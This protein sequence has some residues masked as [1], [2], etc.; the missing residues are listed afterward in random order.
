MNGADAADQALAR[1]G[2]PPGGGAGL[3]DR[4]WQGGLAVV[5]AV[6]AALRLVALGADVPAWAEDSAAPL[7]D[8]WWYVH[9]AVCAADGVPV[10]VITGYAPPVWTSIARLWFEAFGAGPRSAHALGA[11]VG[12]TVVALTARLVASMLGRRAGLAAAALL[13]VDPLHVALSRSTLVYGPAT[14]ALVVAAA[15]WWRGA[16]SPAPGAWRLR[17]LGWALAA[18][19]PL[20]VR[21]PAAGLLAGLLA[22]ELALARSR[23]RR[24]LGPAA[25]AAGVL[26]LVAALLLVLDLD[27]GRVVS[28]NLD[29]L[30]R[31]S[32]R[33]DGPVD[34]LERLARVG[35]PRAGAS[36]SGWVALAPVTAALAALGVGGLL[37]GRARPGGSTIALAALGGWGGAF[38]LGAALLDV[39][40]LRYFLVVAPVCAA[41][42]GWAV[43]GRHRQDAGDRGGWTSAA[44]MAAWGAVV[45][46]HALEVVSPRPGRLAL[47]LAALT[48]GVLL[49]VLHAVGA[50]G[51]RGTASTLRRVGPWL[52]GIA[53]LAA[54]AGALRVRAAPRHALTA[55]A[56][57]PRL[58]GVAPHLAG[59]YAGLLAAGHPIRRSLAPWIG[60][61]VVS[62]DRGAVVGLWDPSRHG[63]WSRS[64]WV[65]VDPGAIRATTL[66]ASATAERLAEERVTHVVVDALQE[67]ATSLLDVLRRLGFEHELAAVLDGG[68]APILLVHVGP[69]GLAEDLVAPKDPV[70]ARARIRA[71]AW[72]GRTRAAAELAG[73]WPG[74]GSARALLSRGRE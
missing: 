65:P 49:P 44:A 59:P 28:D 40:P 72:S 14:L 1:R 37:A 43:V 2:G 20:A 24:A 47:G 63:M 12:V 48:G 29:R 23:G 13:A 52:L 33:I 38:V 30:R 61:D 35:S 16:R 46:P 66:R 17:A 69:R 64:T 8:A 22:G 42:A 36:G 9:A 27:P 74:L 71:L 54:L 15:A 53:A 4:A 18:A 39:R 10:E 21:P 5:L 51:D 60:T 56:V 25:L 7:L 68:P 62:T 41:F 11:V 32:G 55:N 73:R 50:R 3:D 6:A 45:G 57:T 58:L 31:Y 70:V 67:E 19:V 34:L 26:A